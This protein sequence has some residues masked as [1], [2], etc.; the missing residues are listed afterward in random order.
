MISARVSSGRTSLFVSSMGDSIILKQINNVIV[1]CRYICT[2]NSFCK[3]FSCIIIS[4]SCS[5]TMTQYRIIAFRISFIHFTDMRCFYTIC[6]LVRV[7]VILARSKIKVSKS[8]TVTVC[9][10][11]RNYKRCFQFTIYMLLYMLQCH[12]PHMLA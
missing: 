5:S 9:S 10:T 4:Y 12:Y 6:S 1:I 2:C 3:Q 8:L 11:D 7:F